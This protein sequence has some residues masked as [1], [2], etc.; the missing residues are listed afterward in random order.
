MRHNVNTTAILCLIYVLWALPTPAED[1]SLRKETPALKWG[2][3]GNVLVTDPLVF[4]S[5]PSIASAPNGDLFVA[6]DNQEDNSI[7]VFDSI[8]GGKTWSHLYSFADGWDSQYPSIAYAH[9]GDAW[10]YVAYEKINP[11]DTREVWVMRFHRGLAPLYLNTKV[12]GPWSMGSSSEHIHPRITT[13]TI[14]TGSSY[15]VYVTYAVKDGSKYPIYFS[16]SLDSGFTW[17]TPADVSGG[18]VATTWLPTPDIAYGGAGL[19]VAFVKPGWTGSIIANQ[20][21]V[22]KSEDSGSSWLS[23]VQLTSWEYNQYHPAVSVAHDSDSVLVVYTLDYSAD[24][25]L[26]MAYSTDGG[27]TWSLNRSLA[28][29]ASD[30]GSADVEASHDVDD[31]G[32]F[33]I[34][35]H[36][37]VGGLDEIWYTRA[38]TSDPNVRISHIRVDDSGNVLPFHPRPTIAMDPTKT[39]STEACIAWSDYRGPKYDAYFARDWPIFTNGFESGNTTAWSTTVGG[40]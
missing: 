14:E 23:P 7:D 12:G 5:Q 18:S 22:T 35:Y 10:I 32:W 15:S 29:T 40:P 34:A 28:A 39:P 19:F 24:S 3:V 11:G 17:S 37:Y 25:D 31:P 9:D 4:Q 30:E 27:S 21:W 33:H 1:G 38:A 13:D 36:K 6:V 2:G 20:V 26:A 16:R 8:D